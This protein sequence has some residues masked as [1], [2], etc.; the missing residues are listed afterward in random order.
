M[1]MSNHPDT[2]V[3]YVKHWGDNLATLSQSR[4]H[5]EHLVL[6]IGMVSRDIFE[7]QFSNQDPDDVDHCP[8]YCHN[9]WFNIEY[10]E[11]LMKFIGTVHE[12]AQM[13]F[14]AQGMVSHTYIRHQF[15]RY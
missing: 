8:S 3:A 5:L 1:Y 9:K 7:F 13:L 2:L 6:T 12:K 14:E 4:S 15:G 11:T 10:H